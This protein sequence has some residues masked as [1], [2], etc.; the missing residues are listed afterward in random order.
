MCWY[1]MA[2]GEDGAGVHPPTTAFWLCEDVRGSFTQGFW[3]N[4]FSR[5][6]GARG[7]HRYSREFRRFR[8]GVLLSVMDLSTKQ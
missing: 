2:T 8:H 4:S 1:G 6:D 5:I 7:D 3:G